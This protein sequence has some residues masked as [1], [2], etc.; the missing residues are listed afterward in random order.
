ML[1]LESGLI[2]PVLN[3]NVLH[4]DWLKECWHVIDKY[5]IHIHSQHLR[6]PATLRE[7][8]QG[9]MKMITDIGKL[10]SWQLH[11]ISRC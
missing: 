6:T 10:E 5:K 8:N 11:Q 1:Q 7:N 9:F 2:T 4:K 3:V